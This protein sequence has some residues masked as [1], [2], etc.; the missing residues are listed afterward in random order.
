VAGIPYA[1]AEPTGDVSKREELVGIL[2]VH[3][4]AGG[5]WLRPSGDY[6]GTTVMGHRTPG[7]RLIRASAVTSEQSR[8]S[9]SAT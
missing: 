4:L 1:A 5:R 2:Q 8:A 3:H 6:R 7:T 9:A